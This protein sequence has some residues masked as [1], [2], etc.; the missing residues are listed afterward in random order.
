MSWFAG[1][2]DVWKSPKSHSVLCQRSAQK[3]GVTSAKPLWSSTTSVTSCHRHQADKGTCGK[4]DNCGKEGKVAVWPRMFFPFGVMT[5]DS[6]EN[7]QLSVRSLTVTVE[8][9]KKRENLLNFFVGNVD[10]QHKAEMFPEYWGRDKCLGQFVHFSAWFFSIQNVTNER[11]HKNAV[12]WQGLDPKWLDEIRVVG[13]V[14]SVSEKLLW[15]IVTV[16]LNVDTNQNFW[17]CDVSD[18]G[19]VLVKLSGTSLIVVQPSLLETSKSKLIYPLKVELD[20][21]WKQDTGATL[22]EQLLFRSQL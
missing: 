20:R 9:E 4:G 17:R 8:V 19:L 21:A 15:T 1:L 7:F 2:L 13:F 22:H 14:L 5:Q 18:G 10:T 3:S 6:E 12:V 16:W 11:R